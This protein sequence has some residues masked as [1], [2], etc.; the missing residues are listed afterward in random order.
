VV[1]D[2]WSIRGGSVVG[3][4]VPEG[5]REDDDSTVRT[6]GSTS[7]N[8]RNPMFQITSALV[9]QRQSDLRTDARRW[10]LSRVA[11]IA[12]SAKSRNR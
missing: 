2:P 3:T 6:N 4:D 5:L 10:H 9:E 1:D 8:R 7:R 12:R 11:R